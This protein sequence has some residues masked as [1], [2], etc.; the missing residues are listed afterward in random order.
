[1]NTNDH[2]LL[3]QSILT[4]E[5]TPAEASTLIESV[6]TKW[7]RIKD[8]LTQVSRMPAYRFHMREVSGRVL[9]L[10]SKTYFRFSKVK[11][12]TLIHNSLCHKP[13]LVYLYFLFLFK[14]LLHFEV[15]I[16]LFVF[17]FWLSRHEVSL[18]NYEP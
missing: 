15:K 11:F 6:P 7:D 16:I 10:F 3:F 9:L 2:F 5:Y 12:S 13:L 1:M 14:S 8:H 18:V 4:L 17:Q